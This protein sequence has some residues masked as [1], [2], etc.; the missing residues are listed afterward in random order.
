MLGGKKL[1]RHEM[2]RNE[3]R[4]HRYMEFLSK[5]ELEDR[6]KQIIS[7]MTILS[8]EGKIGLHGTNEHGIYWLQV[9]THALEEFFI[10][11]GPYPNGFA[12]GSMSNAE[13]VKASF[14]EPPKAATALEQAGGFSEG[15]ICKFGKYEHLDGMFNKGHIR[16]APASYY[17]DPSL[18]N[19][20]RD[21]ELSFEVQTRADG[22]VFEDVQ[23]I[24]IPAFGQV[25]FKLES[26]TNYYVHC[27]AS[28][29]TYRE[30]DDFDADC[31]IIIDKPRELFQKMM[32]AVKKVKPHFKGF[33]APVKYLD[34]LN[35]SSDDVNVFLAKHFKYSYQNEV[36]T[37]WLPE[38]PQ[39][40]LEP[41]FINVGSMASYARMVRI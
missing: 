31:C 10:R 38:E 1:V 5:S 17:K 12:D 32:K 8:S 9:W 22:L 15:A 21:D 13:I 41:F 33:A 40:Q 4:S 23:G 20:I 39:M 29:Y 11:Y 37:I 27:F 14:P 7:N 18:N 24:K 28:K 16:I 2:W 34:P 30:Y 35:V 36:R 3:Y 25:K 19:A 26:N 6:T